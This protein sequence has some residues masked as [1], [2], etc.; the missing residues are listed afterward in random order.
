MTDWTPEMQNYMVELSGSGL[1]VRHQTLK[2]NQRFEADFTRNQI[3]GRRHRSGLTVPSGRTTAS[4]AIKPRIKRP[5]QPA[6]PLQDISGPIGP[7]TEKAPHGALNCQFIL[8]DDTRSPEFCTALKERG[9][10]CLMHHNLTHQADRY[11]R[12]VSLFIKR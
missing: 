6:Q 7:E 2:I 8:N 11:P 4:D 1:T 5:E 9:S 3:I 12:N 10:Y